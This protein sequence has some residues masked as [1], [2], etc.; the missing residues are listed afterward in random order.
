MAPEAILI[1]FSWGLIGVLLLVVLVP[2]V[3]GTAD[4]L[5]TKNIFLLGGANYVGIAGLNAGYAPDYFRVQEYERSD[6]QYFVVGA[7]TFFLFFLLSYAF[8]KFPRKMAGR[9]LRK[10]PSAKPTTLYFMVIFSLGLALLGIF[11]PP[12]QGLAQACMQIGNKALVLPVALGFAAWYQSRS[13]VILLLTLVGAMAF[14]MLASIVTGSGRRTMMGV[15]ISIPIFW[16]WW[17]LR[18][19]SWVVN[20]LAIG[21]LG[22]ASFV[23]LLAYSQVRHYDQQS[24]PERNFSKAAEVLVTMT[25]KARDSAGLDSM[26]GQN[27]AQTSLAAIHIYTKKLDP[28]PFHTVYYLSTMWIPRAYWEE[29]PLGLGYTLPKSARARGTRATWGPG[30]VGHGFHEGGLH[31]LVFYGIVMGVCLRYLDELLVRQSRNAYLLACISAMA[32]HIFGWTR[33]DI[34]TFSLQIIYAF[35]ALLSFGYVGRL[36]FGTGLVYPRTDGPEYVNNNLF[37]LRLRKPE[38]HSPTDFVFPQRHAS[39]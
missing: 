35:I 14:C 8:F 26:L 23:V 20:G 7:A 24:G 29:K 30:I 19:K 33:G 32:P 31:M 3:R 12:V 22:A 38:Q 18:Y 34:G 4:L 37:A 10:W 17:T 1:P 16:Y 11:P 39:V 9:T 25:S 15:I 5:T 28:E 36:V 6:Y 21:V 13:N 27:A 2:Y